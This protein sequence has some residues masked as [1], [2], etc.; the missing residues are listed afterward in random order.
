MSERR[1]NE[2][3]SPR[4]IRV[5]RWLGNACAVVSAL[6]AGTIMLAITFDV[7]SR[8][9]GGGSVP[10]LLELVETFMIFVVYLGLAHAERTEAHVRMGLFT[11]LLPVTAR[12][13]VRS[14]AMLVAT[15]GAGWFAWATSERAI[16]SIEVREVRPGLLDFPIWPARIVI[17]VGFVL[18]L[19]ENL[20][21]LYE[22]VTGR[23][24][25]PSSTTA[26]P[27][28]ADEQGAVR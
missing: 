1:G 23:H 13:V 10:G 22:H 5:I 24:T 8:T 11:S 18:L 6:V 25:E 27:T 20:A 16:A 17:V 7:V 4:V 9:V 28:L 15:L 26:V 21:K 19:L 12:R 3:G 14:F 2:A